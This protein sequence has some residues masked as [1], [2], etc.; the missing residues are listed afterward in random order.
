MTGIRLTHIGGPTVL[1]EAEGWRILTDPTFDPP[2]KTYSGC[3]PRGIPEGPLGDAPDLPIRDVPSMRLRDPNARTYRQRKIVRLL[4]YR[5]PELSRSTWNRNQVGGRPKRSVTVPCAPGSR[6]GSRRRPGGGPEVLI[7]VPIWSLRPRTRQHCADRQ[8]ENTQ[9][10]SL[11]C[12]TWTS[13][14]SLWS[15]LLQVRAL[16]PERMNPDLRPPPAANPVAGDGSSPRPTAQMSRPGRR[17][18]SRAGSP[19]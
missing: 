5:T 14:P 17:S 15:R 4:A 12:T 3:P 9:L 1:I 19:R 2:G 6:L 11:E 8:T 10:S 16:P 7:Q 18:V 13:P